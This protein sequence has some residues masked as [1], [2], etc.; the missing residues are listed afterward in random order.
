MWIKL[1]LFGPFRHRY[2]SSV[3]NKYCRLQLIIML[4]YYF[5]DTLK[6]SDAKFVREDGGK[7]GPWGGTISPSQARQTSP[8]RRQ[9]GE[10]RNML[11]LL[12]LGN[13]S[14]SN[15]C[16]V[17]SVCSGDCVVCLVS[18]LWRRLVTSVWR[19]LLPGLYWPLV[20]QSVVTSAQCRGS[21]SSAHYPWHNHII[22]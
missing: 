19:P 6:L 8:V 9:G 7:H 14:I 1:Y 3:P 10:R 12:T 2:S 4:R 16:S 20:S 13:L 22:K 21:V 17:C 11:I 15:V 18:M 5:I